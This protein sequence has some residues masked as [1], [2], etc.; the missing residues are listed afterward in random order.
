VAVPTA[1]PETT[2]VVLTDAMAVAPLLQLPDG[3]VLASAVVV[4]VHTVVDPVMDAT[5]GN[6]LTT[7]DL[8]ATA[9]PHALITV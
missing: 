2:P 1:I 6:G 7:I 8:V 4:P 5:E 3:V 9:V